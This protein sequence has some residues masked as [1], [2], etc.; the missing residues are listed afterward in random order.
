MDT[1]ADAEPI[2]DFLRKRPADAPLDHI[3]FAR[4]GYD[5]ELQR[6]ES[7]IKIIDLRLETTDEEIRRLR[8]Q[9]AEDRGEL[10]TLER[11]SRAAKRALDELDGVEP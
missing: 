5:A 9:Q 2:P 3:A 8:R 11:A 6:T 4:A 1:N 7:A 10:A